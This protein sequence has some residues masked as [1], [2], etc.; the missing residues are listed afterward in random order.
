MT[1]VQKLEQEIIK[2]DRK[3]LSTLREWFRK[4]DSDEWDKQIEKDIKEHRFD[5]IAEKALKAHKTGIARE[6]HHRG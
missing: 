1:K 5:S 6:I 2:L 4:Y 3:D